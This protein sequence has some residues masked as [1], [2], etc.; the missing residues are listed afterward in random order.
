MYNMSRYININNNE[1]NQLTKHNNT[2]NRYFMNIT[3]NFV[4]VKKNNQ[5]MFIE[6]AQH[7]WMDEEYGGMEQINLLVENITRTEE[8]ITRTEICPR[9][10]IVWIFKTKTPQS[11]RNGKH[12]NIPTIL[13]KGNA[14][15]RLNRKVKTEIRKNSFL[16]FQMVLHLFL[17]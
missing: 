14:E 3:F 13:R 12:L 8:N 5:L 16:H 17:H 9:M 2:K 15:A 7:F 10:R 4:N 6:P 11:T 1:V